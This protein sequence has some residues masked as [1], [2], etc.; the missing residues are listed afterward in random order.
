MLYKEFLSRVHEL[1]R[2]RQYLEI[3]IRNGDSLA[4]ASCPSVGIDP[5]YAITAELHNKVHL[6]RTTSDEYFTRPQPL[7]PTGG[8]PFDLAFIDGLHLFEFAL[9]DFINAERYSSPG[10]VVIFDDVLPRNVPEAARER[11]TVGWTGDVY[12]ILEVFGRYRPEL[13]VLPVGTKPTGL[14][15]VLG[16][17]PQSTVLAEHYHEIM[18]EF[19]RADPQP[20]PQELLDRVMVLPPQR[21]LES[22]LWELLGR[23]GDGDVPDAGRDRLVE[24]VGRSLGSAFVRAPIPGATR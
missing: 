22:P 12:S 17:D 7:A 20:V 5:Y 14:L 24:V 23:P 4:L 18:A 11:R 10:G 19:R 13:V 15:L 9:R 2:P 8:Q 6:F 16:T 1:L 21:V 3:G